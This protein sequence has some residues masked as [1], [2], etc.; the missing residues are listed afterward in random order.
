MCRSAGEKEGLGGTESFDCAGTSC[1][2]APWFP[3]LFAPPTSILCSFLFPL[4]PGRLHPCA[5][6]EAGLMT[7]ISSCAYWPLILICLSLQ[8]VC[9]H[10]L[11][12]FYWVVLLL[13]FRSPLYILDTSP[14]AGTCFV[15]ISFQS[16][17]C[18]FIF[19]LFLLW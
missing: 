3:T 14:L 13:I 18:L 2:L 5:P 19:S 4:G 6:S 12:I 16:V 17:A 8:N 15:T 1:S 7:K 10:L 11:L 9:S